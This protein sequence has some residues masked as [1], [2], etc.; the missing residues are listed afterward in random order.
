MSL[1]PL[2]APQ[3][4]NR[5]KC[6]VCD[7]FWAGGRT[8]RDSTA[9]THFNLPV[10]ERR[11][12]AAALLHRTSLDEGWGR[13]G[14]K[15]SR[16]KKKKGWGQRWVATLNIQQ[17]PQ[18]VFTAQRNVSSAFTQKVCSLVTNKNKKNHISFSKDP[19]LSKLRLN[20]SHNIPILMVLT[21]N[22]ERSAST[23]LQMDG[24]FFI[25]S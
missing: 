20:S 9:L 1:L 17:K 2:P 18:R 3:R 24:G 12:T 7:G 22:L 19:A 8:R 13:G 15:E 23:S 21:G 4:T 5:W 11:K 10:Q 16:K 25:N 6:Q 14:Q